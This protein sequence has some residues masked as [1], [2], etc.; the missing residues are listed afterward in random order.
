MKKIFIALVFIM[1]TVSFLNAEI[2]YSV[3]VGGGIT[4][5]FDIK[6]SFPMFMG[7]ISA[8]LTAPAMHKDFSF[9]L[10]GGFAAEYKLS[11]M[12]SLQAEVL[13]APKTVALTAE[14]K[15]HIGTTI[16]S[17]IADCTIDNTYIDVPVML[18]LN[19][20]NKFSVLVGPSASFLIHNDF[21]TKLR[22][23]QYVTNAPGGGMTQFFSYDGKLEDQFKSVV[24]NIH[25][26]VEYPLTE[27]MYA[28]FR[29]VQGITSMEKYY[30]ITTTEYSALG[31]EM[32]TWVASHPFMY[33][34]DYNPWGEDNGSIESYSMTLMLGYRF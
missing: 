14:I 27:T 7:P 5:G 34:S 29:Y 13:Y 20:A 19:V 6:Q 22:V 1:A 26:G 18:K 31:A 8:P 4:S 25:A 28:E 3:K 11:E 12:F 33:L 10:M 32:W 30:G 16:Q 23:E 21:E 9:D 2:R 15:D 24:F 17:R